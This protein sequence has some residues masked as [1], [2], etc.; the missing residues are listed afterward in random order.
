MRPVPEAA[1]RFNVLVFS[2]TAGFRHDSIPD[3][4]EA[5]RRL[6]REHGFE[7]DATEDSAHFT[8]ERLAGYGAVIFLNTTG[9][10]LDPE[11]KEAFQRYIQAGGGFVGVH[12]AADTEYDW[13]WY[14]R[15]VGAYF[16][17]HPR[18]QRATINVEDREHLSTRHLPQRWTRTDEWYTFRQS[19]RDIRSRL[20]ILLSLDEDTY[21]GGGMDGDHPIAWF[22][23][24]DG[25]RAWYTGLGHTRESY[26]EPEF[27]QHLLGGIL[28]AADVQAPPPPPT[29]RD[30]PQ[31]ADP[32]R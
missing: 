11:Q 18:I 17:S 26:R 25:G 29:P 20:N 23:E 15:L 14:G 9:T 5:V 12:A 28:W 22:H 27:L 3:G 2:R 24:Y 21:E 1:E 19:G 8:D 32:P 31:Q 16:K 30:E 6:G 4:I 7:V 10:V 13:P